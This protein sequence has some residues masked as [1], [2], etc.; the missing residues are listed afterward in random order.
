MSRRSSRRAPKKAASL[1]PGI[2]TG[3]TSLIEGNESTIA[4]MLS[5]DI[6]SKDSPQAR[7]KLLASLPDC[8][9]MNNLSAETLL[10]RFFNVDVLGM[11]CERRLGVSGKGNEATLAARIVRVWSKPDFEPK[12]FDEK[13][14]ESKDMEKKSKA[15]NKPITEEGDQSTKK[16]SRFWIPNLQTKSQILQ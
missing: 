1:S 15:K 8:M 11:Y 14:D 7:A 3:L 4:S 12:A 2:T 5:V 13:V 9:A 10:A 6:A 16:K